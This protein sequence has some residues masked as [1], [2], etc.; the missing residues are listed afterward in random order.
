MNGFSF[1]LYEKVFENCFIHSSVYVNGNLKLSIFG[2]NPDTKET[3]HF[4]D[5]TLEQN[6]KHLKDNEIVVDYLYKP[7][8]IPQLEKLGILNK[9]VGICAV[10]SVIYP[11]YE[12]NFTKIA[13]KEYFMPELIA[14]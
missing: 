4:V 2:T 5:I 10:Q 9:K 8:F 1:E 7:T 12:V 11:V 14:A 6:S 13:E 3:E